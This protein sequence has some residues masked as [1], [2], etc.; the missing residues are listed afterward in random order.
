[1][2]RFLLFLLCACGL[3]SG[4]A[5]AAGTTATVLGTAS[6][7]GFNY[8]LVKLSNGT[9]P[10]T[11]AEYFPPTGAPGPVLIYILPYN[12]VAWS[13]QAV[14][15][16][17][18]SRPNAVA[19]YSFPDVLQP[20]YVAG[21]SGPILYWDTPPDQ[22][23]WDMYPYLFNGLGVLIL[24]E[25]FYTGQSVDAQRLNTQMAFDFLGSDPAA[26]PTHIGIFGASWGALEAVDATLDAPPSMTPVA[27]V[28]W[29]VPIDFQALANWTTTTLPQLVTP[30][31]LDAYNQFYDPYM[32]RVFASIGGGV[33]GG[34]DWS[35]YNGAYV[36][37]NLKSPLLM[38]HDNWDTMVPYSL[39]RSFVDG[40][41]GKVDGF[42][43]IHTPALDLNSLTFT[44]VLDTGWEAVA[45][46]TFSQAYL[47]TRMKGAS[48]QITI[49]YSFPEMN[50]FFIDLFQRYL[51]GENVGWAAARLE[52]L[53]DPRVTM[54][55][56]SLTAMPV[57]GAF[58]VA[59]ML[60]GWIAT[61][62]TDATVK[63]F[64]EAYRVSVGG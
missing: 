58:Y 11:Y 22:L 53:C 44:H 19:G 41:Q 37:Q 34:S 31:S 38:F 9:A 52:E 24:H 25:R 40:S 56:A 35:R 8:Q 47:M 1:M 36:L 48:D 18:A 16:T 27:T 51:A 2:A 33:G 46:K 6:A 7:A 61:P 43:F 54:V 42:W 29:S 14:D 21:F 32:R 30:D 63:D 20:N 49:G 55:D 4:I 15:I 45:S 10:A 57:S 26:D 64:L 3:T 50:Q 59:Y 17:Y 60:N 23:V 12:G 13:D 62:L 28:A 5:Q 39:S